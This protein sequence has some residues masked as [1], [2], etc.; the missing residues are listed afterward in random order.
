MTPW[1]IAGWVG[2]AL[3][4]LIWLGNLRNLLGRGSDPRWRLTP[5]RYP[6]A[7]PALRVSVVIPARNEE[8]NIEACVRAVA[9]QDHPEL[10]IIVVDDRS[11]DATPQILSRLAETEPRLV[12]VRGE[13]PP[14]GWMGKVAACW[15]GQ[16]EAGGDVLLFLDADVRLEPQAVRAALAYLE[17]SG[18]DGVTLIGRLVTA[19]FWERVVQP[20]VGSLVLAGNPPAKVNDPA[21]P[22]AAMANGQLILVRRAAYDAIGG[23]QALKG[24]VMEDVAFARLMKAR[25]RRLHL[26]LGLTLMSVRM[27][28]G[29][30]EIWSG[31]TKNLFVG[32]HRSVGLTLL[33]W[34][35]VFATA[36]LP[37]LLVLGLPLASGPTPGAF[38][39]SP[40]W[41]AALGICGLIYL[42][43]GI[44]LHRTHHQVGWLWSY[45]L[46]VA[47]LLAILANSALR[48]VLGLGVSWK[49]RSYREIGTGHPERE[50]G[51]AAAGNADPGRCSG[52]KAQELT[53]L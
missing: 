18:A 48:G 20:V 26:L 40:A 41:W 25:G 1:T 9:A 32:L 37:F 50:P 33:V 22:E 51:L 13:G 15:R 6:A 4:L 23:H 10:E 31:W 16:Q 2:L 36:L 5:A 42:T 12:V 34:S 38:L 14:P 21:Y 30:A 3:L 45:P 27:Y 35:G 17:E 28:A 29:L 11:T 39:G 43:Y 47:V 49:G 53:E 24:E 19:S 7:R 8:H 52:E 44:G 46:G